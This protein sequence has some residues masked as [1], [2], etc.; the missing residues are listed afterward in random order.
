[1]AQIVHSRKPSGDV[2]RFYGSYRLE[3]RSKNKQKHGSWKFMPYTQQVLM[4][5]QFLL[6]NNLKLTLLSYLYHA[7]KGHCRKPGAAAYCRLVLLLYL[8]SSKKKDEDPSMKQ[9]R[10]QCLELFL[11]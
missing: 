3:W 8:M 11:L 7:E 5:E 2:T 9:D 6:V 4:Y 1:M 10:S